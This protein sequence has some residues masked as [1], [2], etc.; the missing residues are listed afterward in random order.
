MNV[1]ID[2]ELLIQIKIMSD[3]IIRLVRDRAFTPPK[4]AI[5]IVQDK[6]CINIDV[7]DGVREALLIQQKLFEVIENIYILEEE[8][9]KS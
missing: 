7:T 8:R 2:L 6:D 5:Q 3:I 4:L 1:I 9:L